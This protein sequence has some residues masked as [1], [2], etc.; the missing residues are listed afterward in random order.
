MNANRC[1]LR[2]S[3]RPLPTTSLRVRDWS[4]NYNTCYL[5]YIQSGSDGPC[6]SL[7]GMF[8]SSLHWRNCGRRARYRSYLKLDNLKRRF[9]RNRGL[10]A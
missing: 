8:R 10:S 3:L 2:T 1:S 9:Y 7:S 5:G 4:H 6:G